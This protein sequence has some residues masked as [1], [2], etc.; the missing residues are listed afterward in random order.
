MALSP[1]LPQ[2]PSVGPSSSAATTKLRA[3]NVQSPAH[4]P[5]KT[6][7]P[8]PSQ[9]TDRELT[10]QLNYDVR[11]KYIK[12]MDILSPPLLILILMF[13]DVIIQG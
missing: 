4:K 5:E 9:N 8:L 13:L 6:S 2:S 11:N 3:T 1:L 10:E 7:S 12:G